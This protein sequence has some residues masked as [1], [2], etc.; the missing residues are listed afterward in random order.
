M[1]FVFF[2]TQKNGYIVHMLK[3]ISSEQEELTG[4]CK[5]ERK[6][7]NATYIDE[8]VIEKKTSSK[9]DDCGRIYQWYE[10]KDHTRYIDFT[11]INNRFSEGI[12]DSQNALCD[13]SADLE[14]MLVDIENALCEL[15]EE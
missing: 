2:N 15:T 8:F 4:A 10:I 14:E 13:L 1:Q 3:T 7:A 5:I 12:T 6:F 11:P 9:T